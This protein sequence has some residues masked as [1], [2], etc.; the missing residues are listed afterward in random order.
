MCLFL[1]DVYLN[2]EEI[3]IILFY[4]FYNLNYVECYEK[5]NIIQYLYKITNNL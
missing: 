1:E 3:N 5:E 2:M 4:F